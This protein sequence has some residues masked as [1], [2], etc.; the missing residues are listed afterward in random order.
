MKYMDKDVKTYL[1][2]YH[3]SGLVN[4]IPIFRGAATLLALADLEQIKYVPSKHNYL[5]LRI[6]QNPKRP[7]ILPQKPQISENMWL[8][9][10]N[11][12]L[13]QVN[14]SFNSKSG[15]SCHYYSPSFPSPSR[16]H[17]FSLFTLH[18]FVQNLSTKHK[19]CKAICNESLSYNILSMNPAIWHFIG[20]GELSYLA[21][22]GNEN[23]SAPY[24]KQCQTPRLPVPR[25]K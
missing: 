18:H 11:L 4:S 3:A 6:A 17:V 16:T 9:T 5:P 1:R 12:A 25:Q 13:N 20:R 21:P 22:L 2:G 23:I 14:A 8:K 24:F 15:M 19:I 10:R 7:H